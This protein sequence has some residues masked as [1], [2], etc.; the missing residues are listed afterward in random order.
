MADNQLPKNQDTSDEID[1]GQLFQLIGNGFNAVFRKFLQLFLYLKKNV[2]FLIGLI[3]LGVALGFGLNQIVA[4]RLKAEVILRPNL[5]SKQYLYDVVAE[6]QANI[7][8]KDTVFFKSI[9]ID[10]TKFKGFEVAIEP[11]SGKKSNDLEKKM[12][13][14]ELLEKFQDQ[15]LIGEVVRSEILNT[16]S[17]S[18]RFTVYFKN[19]KEGEKAVKNLVTYINSNPYYTSLSQVTT[20]NAYIR[21]KEN[22][23]LI[24]QIDGLIKA[25][26]KNQQSNDSSSGQIILN[27]QENN[28]VSDLLKQKTSLLRDV[29]RIKQTLVD[30]KEPITVVNFGKTQQVQ[31]S[32]FGKSVFLIPLILI[33]LFFLWSILKFLNKAASEKLN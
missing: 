20:E 7:K 32:M 6:I 31:K 29:D 18:H 9:G 21:I 19:A 26:T 24:T 27:T 8:A 33:G 30:K 1:L 15:T 25:F 5:E 2:L 13:Y 4:K 10:I 23:K 11:V 28:Q 22:K 14:L 12:E 3:I 16:S 17:L